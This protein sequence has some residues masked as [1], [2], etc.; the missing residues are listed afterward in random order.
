MYNNFTEILIL[1]VF[2]KDRLENLMKHYFINNLSILYNKT[3]IRTMMSYNGCL[4]MQ[5]LVN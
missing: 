5:L 3:L 2:G 4:I 1:K